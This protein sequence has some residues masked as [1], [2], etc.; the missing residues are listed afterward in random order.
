MYSDWFAI[1]TNNSMNVFCGVYNH[2]GQLVKQSNE[3]DGWWC[4]E[5]LIKH[6]IQ[7]NKIKPLLIDLMVYHG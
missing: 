7:N 5:L 1:G 2:I 4:N 3:I 6:H